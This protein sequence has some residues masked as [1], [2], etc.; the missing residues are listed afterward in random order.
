MH[1]GLIVNLKIK[2]KSGE[3]LESDN[4]QNA[5]QVNLRLGAYGPFS[6]MCNILY[7]EMCRVTDSFTKANLTIMLRRR[8]TTRTVFQM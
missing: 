2:I 7:S 3:H 1:K 5:W 8:L 6:I 4:T